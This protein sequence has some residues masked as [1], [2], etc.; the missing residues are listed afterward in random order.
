[1]EAGVNVNIHKR[2]KMTLALQFNRATTEN[3][4]PGYAIIKNI[5]IKFTV[6]MEGFHVTSHLS[7]FCKS[8]YLRPP[9]CWFPFSTV[10]YWK[11]QQNVPEFFI[12]LIS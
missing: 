9:S 2:E 10:C 5:Y 6:Q 8:S 4:L 7:Q 12:L 1:M 11:T 3:I